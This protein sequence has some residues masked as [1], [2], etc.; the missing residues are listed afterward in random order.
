MLTFGPEARER[1]QANVWY[2][3]GRGTMRRLGRSDGKV[4]SLRP[5]VVS[6]T[7]DDSLDHLDIL[8][9]VPEQASSSPGEA[10]VGSLKMPRPVLVVCTGRNSLL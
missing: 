10:P 9:T 4:R 2:A 5:L 7:L 1:R 3:G 8:D 6:E